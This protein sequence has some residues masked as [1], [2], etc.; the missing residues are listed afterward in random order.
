MGHN[1]GAEEPRSRGFAS[2]VMKTTACI[3]A[4]LINYPEDGPAPETM[5]RIKLYG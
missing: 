1:Y 2:F 5:A 4:L 3:N